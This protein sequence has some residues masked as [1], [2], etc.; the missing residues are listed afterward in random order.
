M[1]DS[2]EL[3]RDRHVQ[4][5]GLRGVAILLVL[6]GHLHVPFLG[7]AAD[8]GV[9]L[10]FVLSGFLITRLLLEEHQRTGGINLRAFYLR[11][12]RRLLP[13]LGLFLAVYIG[14]AMVLGLPV[15][16]S[17]L[18]VTYTANLASFLNV[19]MMYLQH[20]WSLALEE[21]FYLLWPLLVVPTARWRA[22]R[23]A[24]ILA[25]L[26]SLTVRI[27][28]T[29]ASWIDHNANWQRPDVRADAI[30]LGC[31][32]A[33]SMSR[34]SSHR[35]F[36]PLVATAG[37][38]FLTTLPVATLAN[39]VT[40]FV[41]AAAAGLVIAYVVLEPMGSASKTLGYAPLVWTGR[42]SYGL[43]LWHFPMTYYFELQ[44]RRPSVVEGVIVVVVSF[45][46][47]TASWYLVEKPVLARKVLRSVGPPT[48]T[49]REVVTPGQHSG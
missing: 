48:P 41:M 37:F 8:A 4:L 27:S 45:T 28:T 21:Q 20:T 3:G 18:V 5:D 16:P 42:I 44:S 35:H 49:A 14:A 15:L 31:V 22:G 17:V 11:R 25:A 36:R 6:L 32:V 24:L 7:S 9:S 2:F 29:S 47:A 43:Y 19:P 38:V 39:S 12:A 26:C 1:S 13:A 10:F 30:I 33:L 23:H 40:L 46:L 34:F